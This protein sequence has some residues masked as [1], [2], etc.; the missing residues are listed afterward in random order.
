MGQILFTLLITPI[1]AMSTGADRTPSSLPFTTGNSDAT[2]VEPTAAPVAAELPIFPRPSGALSPRFS[3]PENQSCYNYGNLLVRNGVLQADDPLV[4]DD[5]RLLQ[6]VYSMG[7]II[8][9][10]TATNQTVTDVI[11][12]AISWR[13]WA[14]VGYHFLIARNGAISEGRSLSYMGANAGQIPNRPE[15]CANNRY[16]MD[17]DNDF[18]AIGI[19][20]IG[21][22]DIHTPTSA[23]I[24]SLR[25]LIQSLKSRFNIVEVIGH[26]HVRNTDC[27]GRFFMS[28]LS[29]MF[30]ELTP[31]EREAR[32]H[33]RSPFINRRL[34]CYSCQ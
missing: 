28:R 5:E 4:Q 22:L 12:G 24:E 30:D 13:N 26:Q 8:I 21:N 29:N 16:Y 7:R 11:N 25:N 34:V 3:G 33:S 18:R 19:A 20:L 31:E 23:Q 1:L 10:H 32:Q 6:N 15:D 2:S 27:P 17:R 9:H 14:D